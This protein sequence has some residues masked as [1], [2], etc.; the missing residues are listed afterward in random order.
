VS[1]A[2][3]GAPLVLDLLPD[4]S[5]GDITAKLREPRQTTNGKYA[6]KEAKLEPIET[7]PVE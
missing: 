1:A 7:C 2:I 4:M 3:H 5:V 6:A